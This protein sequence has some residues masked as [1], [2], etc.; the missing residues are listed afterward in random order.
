MKV[1][2]P[3]GGEGRGNQM[4]EEVETLGKAP[5]PFNDLLPR[6]VKSFMQFFY[7]V[8][9]PPPP[10]PEFLDPLRPVLTL[11]IDHSDYNIIYHPGSLI[12]V[13]T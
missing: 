8:T 5:P 13:I 9:P 12:F 2:I 4:S 3:F 7:S 6:T 10:P 11:S 1:A